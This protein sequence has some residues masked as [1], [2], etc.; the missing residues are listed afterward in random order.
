M[1]S[2][3]NDRLTTSFASSIMMSAQ[4]VEPAVNLVNI[5][6]FLKQQIRRGQLGIKVS[7]VVKTALAEQY[8]R[9]QT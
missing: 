2:Q 6:I 3:K 7:T 4:F 1:V 9:N 5:D 8:A